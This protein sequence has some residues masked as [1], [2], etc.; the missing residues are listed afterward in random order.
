M[1]AQQA[2]NTLSR[3]LTHSFT[4]PRG[5]VRQAV[6]RG[7]AVGPAADLLTAPWVRQVPRCP[8][9][10]GRPLPLRGPRRQRLPL[11]RSPPPYA[12]DP[13]GHPYIQIDR[14]AQ[15][16]AQPWADLMF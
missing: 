3:A 7:A 16:S 14:S 15:V 1:K 9:H 11:G 6:V 4:R 8:P 5:H 10:R 12:P 13:R 2:R